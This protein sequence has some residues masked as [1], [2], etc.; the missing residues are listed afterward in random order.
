MGF[1]GWLAATVL[2]T[3]TV[4]ASIRGIRRP[5]T[6][7]CWDEYD[8]PLDTGFEGYKCVRIFRD[9]TGKEWYSDHWF[10]DKNDSVD[11]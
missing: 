2:A 10:S 4:A 9:G 6:V 8:E 11:E 3:M 7:D 1:T 5:E